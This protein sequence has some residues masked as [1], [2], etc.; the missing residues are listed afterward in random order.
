MSHRPVVRG[1]GLLPSLP[2][3]PIWVPESASETQRV[4]REGGSGPSGPAI[5]CGVVMYLTAM[6]S[7]GQPGVVPRSHPY[8]EPETPL[9]HFKACVLH[10]YPHSC[11][12]VP[13]SDS[14]HTA[15]SDHFLFGSPRA[16]L[17]CLPSVRYL[18]GTFSH[19]CLHPCLSSTCRCWLLPYC[20]QTGLLSSVHSGG[21]P[22]SRPSSS[23]KALGCL[24]GQWLL[25][26][27]GFHS[28]CHL[29]LDLLPARLSLGPMSLPACCG[30]SCPLPM[31]C[32]SVLRAK[33]ELT[34]LWQ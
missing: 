29:L 16:S 19:P 28:F 25:S 21:A 5:P 32:P 26:Q 22:P 4:E 7:S 12:R 14:P 30:H 13:H 11:A 6:G 23:C 1:E 24:L 34:E 27:L 15:Q 33:T 9:G 31:S 3:T 8:S 20:Y 10:C 17:A 18:Q 2:P